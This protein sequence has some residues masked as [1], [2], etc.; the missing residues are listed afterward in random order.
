MYNNYYIPTNDT[1]GDKLQ[2]QC[3][4]IKNKISYCESQI[5]INEK[6][7]I[8]IQKEIDNCLI[9]VVKSSELG[10]KRNKNIIKLHGDLREETGFFGFDNDI[11]NHYVISK[12]DYDLY[13]KQHEA[14][15][16]LMRISLLQE[17][18]CLIGF[19]GEDPNFLGWISWVRDVIEKGSGNADEVKL[20]LVD[21]GPPKDEADRSLL[22]TNHRIRKIYLN[23]KKVIDFLEKETGLKLDFDIDK[24]KALLQLF[25]N[26][27]S[28]DDFET[29]KI[30]LEKHYKKQFHDAW[31][32]IIINNDSKKLPT[33]FDKNLDL[34]IENR[35]HFTLI[36]LNF[37]GIHYLKSFIYKF[38]KYIDLAKNKP[39][40]QK[41]IIKVCF[42]AFDILQLYP[43]Q[44]WESEQLEVFE[45][46]LSNKDE[47]NQYQILKQKL[48]IL[49]G[50]KINEIKS[51][52][53]VS[54]L[55]DE[56]IS[57]K[58]L[59]YLF[60]FD[61][62]SAKNEVEKWIPKTGLFILRKVGFLSYFSPKDALN[63]LDSKKGVIEKSSFELLTY[64]FQ[65]SILLDSN[66]FN[67][68]IN[69]KR[70]LYRKLEKKGFIGIYTH[71]KE[72]SEQF[73][74]KSEKITPYG[75]GRF[76]LSNSFEFSNDIADSGK[77][78]Q[79]LHLCIHFGLPLQLSGNIIQSP[80][81]WYKILKLNFENYPLPYLF[82]S[83]NY[84]DE[85]IIRRIGQDYAYSEITFPFVKNNLEVLLKTYLNKETPY[86]FKKSILLLTSEWL[87]TV[88]PK[89]WLTIFTTIIDEITFFKEAL[90]EKRQEEFLFLKMVLPLLE[91]RKIISRIIEICLELY[92]N[93]NTSVELL[94]YLFKNKSSSARKVKTTIKIKKL[95]EEKI[96]LVPEDPIIWFVLGNLNEI[97]TKKEI[98]AIEQIFP[99]IAFE[100]IE[101]TRIWKIIYFFIKDN[102]KL[103]D[104]YKKELLQS[105]TIFKSGFNL[106]EKGKIKSF[107]SGEHFTSIRH[108]SEDSIWNQDELKLL[109]ERL[110]DE[111]NLIKDWNKK[112]RE[113]KF[114]FI[115]EEMIDFLDF[116]KLRL[117]S[118]NEFESTYEFVNSEL[119]KERGYKTIKDGFLSKDKNVVLKSLAE[120]SL[121]LYDKKLKNDELKNLTLLLNR[122]L[123][124]NN[125]YIEEVLNYIAVWTKEEKIKI[126]FDNFNDL[127]FLILE[128]Y[129]N[130]IPENCDKPF[131]LKQLIT[132][133]EYYESKIE[134][135]NE[136][137]DFYKKI[138]KENNYQFSL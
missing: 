115:Y 95:I 100:K 119:I 50:E 65:Y 51:I 8:D 137:L 88:E 54:D 102:P 66:S 75:D 29:P 30:F 40:L 107:R 62:K 126:Y 125:F 87:I 1:V 103:V 113:T 64:Y 106:D 9:T 22:F 77:S 98:I 69:K 134:Q 120:F 80:E 10:I 79:Y 59:S 130:N 60:D 44:I 55:N 91:D 82:Y 133:Y 7:K 101:N 33:S 38:F 136:V 78:F 16:Q 131:V 110:I 68:S 27:L 104:I 111:I 58:I 43:Q 97:L 20:F 99:T 52:E 17:S 39:N 93:K 19:S 47:K 18:Y 138:K 57:N 96:R 132:I 56:I 112:D 74:V 63:Y 2:L 61:F 70:E 26:Y 48:G 11:R 90:N 5:K 36:E 81:I 122:L 37:P 45:K 67:E 92:T 46:L 127:I 12:E 72:L 123:F 109:F 49:N 116:E 35:K 21:V 85:K 129:I 84:T 105:K 118:S 117:V 94:F 14:F 6:E 13:P 4:E 25:L 3:N 114:D 23:E 135:E 86:S 124:D 41:K 15:T 53:I 121:K 71:F 28:I 83:L 24:R 89:K 34:L 31:G 76:N 128:K 42:I 32:K 108:L 73:K